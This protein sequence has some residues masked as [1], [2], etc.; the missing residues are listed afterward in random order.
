[1]EESRK[2]IVCPV[3]VDC[4]IEVGPTPFHFDLGLIDPPRA[5]GH[6]QMRPETLPQLGGVSLDPTDNRRVIHCHPTILKHQLKVAVAD[7]EHQIPPPTGSPRVL[8]HQPVRTGATTW[9]IQRLDYQTMP[10]QAAVA[11]AV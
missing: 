5:I 3:F 6:S 1:L 10:G 2:S 4:P 8:I 11:I 7:G 9:L